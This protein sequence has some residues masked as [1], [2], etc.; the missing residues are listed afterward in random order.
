M[1]EKDITAVVIT[2]HQSR[3]RDK[4]RGKHS[5]RPN[6]AWSGNGCPQCSQPYLPILTGDFEVS[7]YTH[8]QCAVDT[9]PIRVIFTS[10]I[11]YAF[12]TNFSIALMIS[13]TFF[14]LEI[15]TYKNSSYRNRYDEKIMPPEHSRCHRT[16]ETPVHAEDVS[17]AQLR[18]GNKRLF[19]K[20][21]VFQAFCHCSDLDNQG[22]PIHVWWKLLLHSFLAHKN[23]QSKSGIAVWRCRCLRFDFSAPGRILRKSSKTGPGL[24][25]Q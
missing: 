8:A 14:P 7:S 9:L 17:H 22:L 16:W 1:R 11:A 15:P 12:L 24:R 6:K 10:N 21:L 2:K 23:S 4:C 19:Y 13:S 20:R 25:S 18:C 3:R 5:Q